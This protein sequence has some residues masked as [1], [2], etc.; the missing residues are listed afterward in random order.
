MKNIV[1]KIKLSRGRSSPVRVSLFV[2]IPFIFT[3]FALL[4]FIIAYYAGRASTVQLF[5]QSS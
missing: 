5:L 1:S 3:G 2:L 4:A